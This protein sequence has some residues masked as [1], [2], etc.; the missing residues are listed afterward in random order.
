MKRSTMQ[1]E[2]GLQLGLTGWPLQ[3]TLS[4]RIHQAALSA[5]GLAGEYRLY[6]VAPGP[7][8]LA[9]LSQLASRV[10]RAELQG[11]N[12]TI[13]HKITLRSL[14]D[15]LTPAAAAIG[16]VNTLY[17]REG[18]VC[19]ENTDAA[20]FLEAVRV[21]FPRLF[22]QQTGQVALV[23]GAGGAAR[24]VVYA[25]LAAGWQVGVATRSLDAAERL[26]GQ[27][28]GAALPEALIALQLDAPSVGAWIRSQPVALVVNATSAGMAPQVDQNPWPEALSLPEG[29]AVYDLIY[30]PAETCLVRAARAAG[31][32]AQSGL[33]MLVEQAAGSLE[34]W[35]GL[36]A[37]RAAMQH[38]VREVRERSH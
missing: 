33:G 4:P 27:F 6:P 3:H 1:P 22:A 18:R 14:V 36:P 12:V 5:L 24:A 29:A 17:H 19:G 31:L 26:V 38:A 13:P 21:A 37:P 11:L 8:C 25:L 15:E 28:E 20:G 35:T 9:A 23:L 32:A 10:R 2:T 34:L 16:A 7:E 30:T